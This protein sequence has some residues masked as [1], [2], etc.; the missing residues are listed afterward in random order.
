[1]GKITKYGGAALSSELQKLP[2]DPRDEKKFYFHETRFRR[3]FVA[4]VRAIFWFVIKRCCSGA[5][6][7]PP[8]GPVVL[9]AN[10]LTNF[11]V[12]P[13]QLCLTRPLFFMAKAELHKNP[14]M[15]AFF[16]NVGAFPVFRGQQDQWAID[17]AGKVLEHGQ[18]LAMFPEGTRSKGR[19][20]KA[21]KTGAARLAIQA[22]CPI[23]PVAVA[24][25]QQMFKFF[26][27][28]TRVTI[29]I[30]EALHPKPGE[31]ALALTDRL[32]F[33]IADMLPPELRGVYSERVPGF[34]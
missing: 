15:D 32:M 11:D 25:T 6:N 22:Q 4:F 33:T 26:P 28:R 23:V 3:A 18:V 5:E 20:L 24:G 21:A 27:R 9:A 2:K 7:L 29:T 12:F 16:R 14:I 34:E 19:G 8:E 17:H 1:V 31:S 13:M 10:H 30:G